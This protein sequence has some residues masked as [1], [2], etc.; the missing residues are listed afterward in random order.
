M[1]NLR[2]Q[3]LNRSSRLGPKRSKTI[4]L[5]SPSIPYHRMLGMP[6]A[7]DSQNVE[8][9]FP[10]Q[11]K[12]LSSS[13]SMQGMMFTLLIQGDTKGDS[14]LRLCFSGLKDLL[15]PCRILYNLDS[16]RSWGCFVLID[17]CKWFFASESCQRKSSPK[18][19]QTGLQE[20]KIINSPTLCQL[21]RP[22]A[23]E[24][25]HHFQCQ[26]MTLTQKLAVYKTTLLGPELQ[27]KVGSAHPNRCRRKSRCRFSCLACI[28][29][30]CGCPEPWQ[31]RSLFSRW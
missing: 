13:S 21:P 19:P 7:K 11:S 6:A 24:F 31:A 25:L 18:R 26:Q 20:Q 28:A 27:G 22:S 16:Y 2:L 5:Y 14:G 8:P 15:P 9:L 30:R 10:I 17:S 12:Y 3:K 29:R 23:S 4:T 1:V